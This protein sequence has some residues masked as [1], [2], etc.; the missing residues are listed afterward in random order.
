MSG[1]LDIV[2][3]GP[4]IADHRTVAA[5]RA[6]EQAQ[7][8]IGYGPY[9]DQCSELLRAEQLVMRAKMGQ[10]AERAEEALVRAQRGERVAL[11]SSGDAGVYGMASRT[12]KR[13][14]ALA[15]S[16]RPEVNMIPGVTAALAAGAVLGAPLADD[17]ASLS[18]SDLHIEWATIERRLR[19]VAEAG[20]TLA[21]YNPRSRQRQWQLDRVLELLRETR[22][23]DTPV[24]VVTDAARE[25]QSAIC[26]TLG[27]LDPV[28]VTMRTLLLVAGESTHVAGEWMV[29][30]RSNGSAP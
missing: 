20:L 19:A 7:V 6:I 25:G 14:A 1:V 29:A 18:L 13:A 2:G 22:G 17:W 8:V 15:P 10:E 27:E 12:L 9:V 21:L 16:E 23:A 24:G 4:G 26:T 3:L 5:T 28:T 30:E 11:V